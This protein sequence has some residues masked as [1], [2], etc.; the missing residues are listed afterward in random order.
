[1]KKICRGILMVWLA[2]LVGTAGTAFTAFAAAKGDTTRFVDGTLIIGVE[3]SRLTVTEAKNRIEGYFN[4]S[5]ALKIVDADGNEEKIQDTEIGFFMKV[6][7]GLEEILQKENESGREGGPG[8][9]HKYEAQAETGFNEELLAKALQNLWCV[10]EA[11][12]T[13]DAHLSPYEEGKDFTIIPEVQGN[14]VDMER[15]TETVRAALREQKTSVRLTDYD[16]YKKITLTAESPELQQL[17]T[18]MNAYKD[19]TITYTFGESREVLSGLDVIGWITGS[20]GTEILVDET[21]AAAYVGTL[22]E[23]YDTY[24]KPHAYRTTSGRDVSVNGAYG[25]KINQEEETKALVALVKTCQSQEREPVYAITAASRDGYD[26][27]KTYIE[28][29]LAEQHLYFY[30][31]GALLLDSQFVSGN[32]SK[33][34]TTPP[35]LFTLYYK[36]TDKVLRGEDY[37][38]PVKYWMPFNGGIGLHDASWRGSFGGAIYKT[39][40]SHGCINLPPKKAAAIYEHAYK[41]IPIICCD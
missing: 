36:Q 13:T 17:C 28:I 26:F 24:G 2:V 12:P 25:W 35:G 4:G 34:W 3:V 11:A 40:G 20:S 27:G 39:N 41:G 8:S 22:A 38:T 9:D 6:T 37:E 23:K 32:V 10:R 30:E 5:Y 7:G 21:K 14:E 18:V 15:L 16:C 1:M 33:G 29:D 31:N 19:V